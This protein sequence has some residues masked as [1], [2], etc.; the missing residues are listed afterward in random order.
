MKRITLLLALGMPLAAQ[1]PFERIQ[2]ADL[3]PGNWLTYSGNYHSHRFS[4]LAQINSSN[5]KRLTPAWVYQIRAKDK[6]ETTPLVIDGIMYISEPPSNVTALDTRTGRPMW[7]YQRIIP[8]DVR[9]CCGQV[10]RGVAA[11]DDLLFVGTVDAH[12]VALDMKSGIV[13]WDSTVADYK[14]G[15][16]I[17][18]APLAVRDKIVVGVAG[19]E[20][21]VRGLVAAYEAK[22]GKQ[23]WRFYTVP[24]PGEPGNETWAGESWKT[25]S[26]T[27]WVTG[28]FDPELNLIYWGTGNP[29]PDW[30][31]DVRAG[32]N[33]FSDSLLALDADSGRLRWYYQFTPHDVHDWD[34]T[35]VPVLAEGTVRGEK[36]KLVLFGNRNGFYY[37]LDRQNGQFLAGR[38]YVRISW[39]K[40]LDDSGKPVR[41]PNTFP[42]EQGTKVY[43]SVPGG[44][45]WFSPSYSPQTNL[46]YV[47]AREEGA[48]YYQG[49]A[50]YK[51]GSLFNAG[52]SRQIPGEEPWG[53]I[54]ALKPTTGELQWE[55]KLHSPPW[56]GVLSTAG[57]LVFGGANEGQFFALDAASGRP[58]WNFQTGGQIIANPISYL[59]NGRQQVAIAAGSAI[60]AFALEE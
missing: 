33:L 46:F 41:L 55:F 56:A 5:V 44:T 45:N 35:E 30:N 59:S 17:T 37:V 14:I 7:R 40:G 47:A 31:G 48:I 58:L 60:F 12:L 24:F 57:N 16:S 32:D 26:A 19:G 23:A 52:G 43:P 9:V 4:R 1:V 34:S 22:T 49:E 51:A 3:E 36:R 53:A 10:N 42:T 39:A 11:L 28:S 21:G 38:P 54:R 13:R 25:G 2:K 15:Y 20:Y 50:E 29:G 27:T 8:K 6:V 18:V